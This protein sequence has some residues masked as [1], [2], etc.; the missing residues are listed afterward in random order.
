MRITTLEQLKGIKERGL[1]KIVPSLPRIA[2]GM[3]TCGIGNGAEELYKEFKAVLSRRKIPAHLVKTGCFGFCAREPLVNIR[4]PHKPL[5][6]LEKA[7]GRR[8]RNN[9]S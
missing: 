8:N 5:V 3:D 9:R 2:V 4:L 7:P 1:R 6:I